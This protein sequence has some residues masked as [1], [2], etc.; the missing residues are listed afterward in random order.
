LRDYLDVEEMSQ[1]KHEF[2]DGEIVAMAGGTPEHAALSAAVVVLL[3]RHLLGSRRRAYSADLRLRVP[4]TGLAT[5]ADAS[6]VC[7]ELERDPQSPTHVTNPTLVVEVLSPSSEEYDRGA[8]REHYQKLDSLREYVLVAQD[9]RRIE[10]F[11]R[12]ESDRW[13]HRVHEAGTRFV[14]RSIGTDLAVDEIY[15]AADVRVD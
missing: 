5:Y 7:G 13:E 6:V 14:L 3:G 4:A 2:L 9:R 1:V 8:K 11:A 15:A 12:G 10:V